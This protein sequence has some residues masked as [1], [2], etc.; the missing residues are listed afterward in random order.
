MPAIL[1]PVWKIVKN[2]NT[3]EYSG[4]TPS[5]ALQARDE[6]TACL[7]PIVAERRL[8]RRDDLISVL[9]EAEFEGERLDDEAIYSFC[10]LLFPSGSD[11]TYRSLGSLIHLLLKKPELRAL[12]EGSE[13]DRL[14]LVDEILRFEPAAAMIPRKCSKATTLGGMGIEEGDWTLFGIAAANRDPAVFDEPHQF[15]PGRTTRHLAFG[16][17]VHV[18]LGQHG[19]GSTKPDW[20]GDSF[21]AGRFCQRTN[22]EFCH[23]SWH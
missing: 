3:I 18:C 14:A 6:F 21:S 16:N 11:T 23:Q 20:I 15:R 17:G 5:E 12:A 13:E 10:R 9:V 19:V 8:E 2:F 4:G 1:Y 7:A 22:H